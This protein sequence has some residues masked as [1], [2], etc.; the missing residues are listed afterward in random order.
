MIPLKDAPIGRPL[1]V[2]KFT[3][4]REAKCR[5]IGLGILP[6]SRIVITHKLSKD[7]PFSVTVNGTKIVVGRGLLNR[8]FVEE[9]QEISL[10][11]CV[12][13]FVDIKLHDFL[14]KLCDKTEDLLLQNHI[15][16]ILRGYRFWRG[17]KILF[18][19]LPPIVGDFPLSLKEEVGLALALTSGYE[20]IVLV[21][22]E[23]KLERDLLLLLYLLD[24]KK[25][26]IV[27]VNR[28]R[29][30]YN[31]KLLSELLSVVFLPIDLK[32]GSGFET[33]WDRLFYQQKE[34]D[35]S[36]LV[37]WDKCLSD[38][39]NKIADWIKK[40]DCSLVYPPQA[41]AIKI[42]ETE[43]DLEFFFK[44][45][46]VQ[47]ELKTIIT[48]CQENC[49]VHLGASIS[50]YIL[51][52]RKALVTGAL[53]QSSY[54]ESFVRKVLKAGLTILITLT[55]LYGFS[56][57]LTWLAERLI[58]AIAG[59]DSIDGFWSLVG[60][61]VRGKSVVS[62]SVGGL[63]PLV[64]LVALISIVVLVGVFL[65]YIFY[66]ILYETNIVYHLAFYLDALLHY[67]GFH[68]VSLLG[69]LENIGCPLSGISRLDC[70]VAEKQDRTALCL[71][72]PFVGCIVKFLIFAMIFSANFSVLQRGI[73]LSLLL[74]LSVMYA[75]FVSWLAKYLYGFGELSHQK[76]MSLPEIRWPGLDVLLRSAVRFTIN[77]GKRAFWPLVV[78]FG[79][80]YVF[81]Y[82]IVGLLNLAFL[83]E[84]KVSF[85]YKPIGLQW[86]EA[87]ALIFGLLSKELLILVEVL[88]RGERAFLELVGNRGFLVF[89]F[90]SPSCFW[91]YWKQ[92]RF[93]G[94]LKS[95]VW[96]LCALGWAWV[97]SFFVQ[98]L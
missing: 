74:L 20:V 97:L 26:V 98:F 96:F 91:V 76:A 33:L 71:G 31:L 36:S 83:L 9:D 81:F 57:S 12:I 95:V 40:Q 55:L 53:Q 49:R 58:W 63:W 54:S 84:E 79:L 92:R 41:V 27:A 50:D 93:F 4:G 5:L 59:L 22:D 45:K 6:G 16:A 47:E 17:Q 28:D 75:L 25:K 42:L 67:F 61:V 73:M 86:Q 35:F 88:L 72:A 56:L 19:G 64:M 43:L 14:T 51:T 2:V 15:P 1:K 62:Y 21:T 85:L 39:I 48:E 70:F 34:V 89:L 32:S 10:K 30:I 37:S 8:I 65:F 82:N 38:C 60:L 94:W 3:C 77:Y 29:N 78:S 46:D 87:L 7:G 24:F 80:F 23:S 18:D 68:N 90:F 13:G 44:R 52:L 66:F 11:A 69:L